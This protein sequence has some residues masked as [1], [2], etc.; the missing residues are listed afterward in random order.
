M[1]K[2]VVSGFMFFFV[3][4]LLCFPAAHPIQELWVNG[5]SLFL[6]RSEQNE[7]DQGPRFLSFN[8]VAV[9]Y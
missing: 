4:D 9:S 7:N 2:E 3:L 6:F 1:N 5:L 8:S